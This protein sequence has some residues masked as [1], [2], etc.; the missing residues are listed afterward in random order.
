L[1]K[2]R[3]G[4]VDFQPNRYLLLYQNDPFWRF[5]TCLIEALLFTITTMESQHKHGWKFELVLKP[6]DSAC[7]IIFTERDGPSVNI[8]HVVF[9]I[10]LLSMY[11]SITSGIMPDLFT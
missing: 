10:N 5:N 1:I 6:S 8:L 2:K 7:L 9:D 3:Q 11:I 4:I